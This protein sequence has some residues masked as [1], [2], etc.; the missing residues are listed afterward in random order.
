MNSIPLT[1]CSVNFVFSFLLFM[2]P[3]SGSAKNIGLGIA[4]K[5]DTNKDMF[6][7]S[8]F[9]YEGFGLG[10]IMSDLGG[11]ISYSYHLNYGKGSNNGIH[12]IYSDFVETVKIK[13][14]VIRNY[15]LS[16]WKTKTLELSINHSL[17]F[18][19]LRASRRDISDDILSSDID[20]NR[21]QMQ[22]SIIR[23]NQFSILIGVG[24]F[25]S[26]DI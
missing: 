19:G 1:N 9:A 26:I 17:W 12:V 18:L 16:G 3:F 5:A 11:G 8:F 4:A 21:G 7:N 10:V 20:F 25:G 15:D 2:L 24:A 22:R 23:G 14:R 6:V 13:D